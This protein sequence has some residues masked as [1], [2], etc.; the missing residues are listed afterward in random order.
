MLAMPKKRDLLCSYPLVSKPA[1]PF[2]HG[3]AHFSRNSWKRSESVS[4]VTSTTFGM[5][6]RGAFVRL[7]GTRAPMISSSGSPSISLFAPA[8]SEGGPRGLADEDRI[9]GVRASLPMALEGVGAASELSARSRRDD[10]VLRTIMVWGAVRSRQEP[11]EF[12]GGSKH[13]KTRSRCPHEEV[14]MGPCAITMLTR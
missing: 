6:V 9:S 8:L 14:S 4:P 1:S 7:P 2:G 11:L 3:E 5:S 12:C 13:A 10:M